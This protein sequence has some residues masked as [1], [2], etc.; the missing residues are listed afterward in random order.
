MIRQENVD[1]LLASGV[2]EEVAMLTKAYKVVKAGPRSVGAIGNLF[3]PC[4]HC[5][6]VYDSYIYL[7]DGDTVCR[8]CRDKA[9]HGA[10]IVEMQNL[11]DKILSDTNFEVVLI[12]TL[13]DKFEN[14]VK[15]ILEKV[16]DE[17]S[18]L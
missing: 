6:R 10:F 8:N 16:K 3:H 15:D 13:K 4:P 11:L 12:G 7:R 1:K 14:G 5:G 9:R 18:N 17:V 2:M